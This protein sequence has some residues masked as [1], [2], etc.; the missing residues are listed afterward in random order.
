MT[1]VLAYMFAGASKGIN[2]DKSFI[3]PA[4]C[5]HNIYICTGIF[6]NNIKFG[7]R[8]ETDLIKF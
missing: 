7:L 6:L 5:F 1:E 4:L 3:P 8:P 2:V